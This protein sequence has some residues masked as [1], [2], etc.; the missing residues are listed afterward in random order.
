MTK[1]HKTKLKPQLPVVDAPAGF[2]PQ[3]PVPLSEAAGE[4]FIDKVNGTWCAQE[5]FTGK[6]VLIHKRAGI[7]TA[8]NKHG[9]PCAIPTCVAEMVG[10]L[11]GDCTLDG[12]LC[13]DVYHVFDML[14]NEGQDYRKQPYGRR[15]CA[16]RAHIGNRTGSLRVVRTVTGQRD[17]RKFHEELRARNADGMVYRDLCMPCTPGNSHRTLLGFRMRATCTCIVLAH[18]GPRTVALTLYLDDGSKQGVNMGT[19]QIPEDEPLPAPGKVVDVNYVYAIQG[20]QL[21]EPELVCVRDDVKTNV[22]LTL[23]KAKLRQKP[24]DME[25]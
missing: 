21:V 17:V 18:T 23:A 4:A 8:T 12:K 25:D 22:G 15:L 13:V 5:M 1:T 24:N 9:K 2:L 19:V 10:K 20:I 11:H 7:V 6:R 3:L 16:V 14:W